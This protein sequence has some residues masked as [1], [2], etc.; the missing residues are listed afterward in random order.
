MIGTITSDT[1]TV[2]IVTTRTTSAGTTNTGIT[3]TDSQLFYARSAA[4]PEPTVAR[5]VKLRLSGPH[6]PAGNDDQVQVHVYI[7][8]F[9][10][11]F[12]KSFNMRI[13]SYITNIYRN[14]Y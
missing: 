6:P 1:K 7:F 14:F 3:T 11:Y 13:N 12:F 8:Y 5:F 10:S 2:D 4:L 9:L